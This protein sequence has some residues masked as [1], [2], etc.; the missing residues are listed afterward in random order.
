M[1]F[2]RG[3]VQQMSVYLSWPDGYKP[4]RKLM[5]ARRVN[6]PDSHVLVI[7]KIRDSFYYK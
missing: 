5:K 2:F 3:H 6:I 7:I 1:L 4:C